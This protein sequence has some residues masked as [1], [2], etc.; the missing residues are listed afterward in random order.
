MVLAHGLY[1][2]AP[3]DTVQKVFGLFSYGGII[4]ALVMQ[5]VSRK[6]AQG[7][8]QDV[9]FEMRGMFNLAKVDGPGSRSDRSVRAMVTTFAI[10]TAKQSPIV[11]VAGLS[12]IFKEI[13]NRNWSTNGIDDLGFFEESVKKAASRSKYLQD[14]YD[15]DEV[16]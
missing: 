5:G 16:T 14:K 15:N 6:D 12:E 8:A 9:E 1:A 4:E 3:I 10:A 7:G 11:L 2:E 13:R